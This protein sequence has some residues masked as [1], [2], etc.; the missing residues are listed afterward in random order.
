MPV[1]VDYKL[2]QFKRSEAG[3]LAEEWPNVFEPLAVRFLGLANFIR[4]TMGKG[5][6]VI[7]CLAR[8]PDENA[9]V[10][11][12]PKSMHMTSPIR[13]I[14]FRRVVTA[15]SDKEIIE[16][17]RWWQEAGPGW[18]FVPEGKPFNNKVPHFHVEADRRVKPG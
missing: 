3:R 6:L 15:W 4:N 18:D 2:I 7:T 12:V 1:E 5:P 10:G 11:G 9:T 8:T 17:R 14:D 13:A 16:A